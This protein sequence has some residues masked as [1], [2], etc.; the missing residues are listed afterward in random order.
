MSCSFYLYRF[1]NYV[2][3]GFPIIK[4]CNPGEHYGTPCIYVYIKTEVKIVSFEVR[5]GEMGSCA[6]SRTVSNE[7][8]QPLSAVHC[9]QTFGDIFN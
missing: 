5:G 7:T 8:Y 4:F 1:R 2:S 6:L 9:P 3:S